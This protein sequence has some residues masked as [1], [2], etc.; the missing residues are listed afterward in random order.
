[1]FATLMETSSGEV[2]SSSLASLLS[3]L[4]ECVFGFSSSSMDMVETEDTE[5]ETGKEGYLSYRIYQKPDGTQYVEIT[6]CDASAKE[7]MEIPKEIKG[8]AVTS[9]GSKAFYWCSGLTSIEIP[10]GVTSIGEGAFD[11]CSGLTSIEIPAGVTSMG[12]GAFSGCTSLT[13]ITIPNSMKSFGN[14]TFKN[15]TSLVNIYYTGTEEQWNAIT[16]GTDWNINMGLNVEG[17]TVIHYN[18]VPE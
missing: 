17:G 12:S 18:Y 15:C 4:L 9:I 6:D 10:A 8:I 11:D 14:W 1:M 5:V 16:K 3:S 7:A 2:V 13:S